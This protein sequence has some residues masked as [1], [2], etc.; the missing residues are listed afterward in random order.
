MGPTG[1]PEPS[2]TYGGLCE[3]KS[4]L[5]NVNVMWL[6]D[7][8]SGELSPEVVHPEPRDS[9]VVQTPL[10]VPDVPVVHEMVPEWPAPS[11]QLKCTVAPPMRV[12]LEDLTVTVTVPQ[13]QLW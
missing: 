12:L 3:G 5:V 11:V 8:T 13:N 9:W 10:D 1:L 6:A 4:M 7:G 2:H